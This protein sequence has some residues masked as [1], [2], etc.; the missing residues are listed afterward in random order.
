[1]VKATSTFI[2][3]LLSLVPTITANCEAPV[4]CQDESLNR[5]NTTECQT[6]HAFLARGSNSGFPGHLGPL[7]R[8]VCTNLTSGS[9]DVT[10]GYENIDYPANSS[11]DGEG[12]WCKS[13]HI[14]ATQGQ[15]Q[16]K[17]Y[18][19]RCPDAKLVLLGFSQGGSVALDVL[20]G[21]GGEEDGTV[22][23]CIQE[24]SP[25]LNPKE[26]PGS[27]IVAAVVFGAVRRS[28]DQPFTVKNGGQNYNGTTPRTG[29]LAE[30]LAQFTPVLREYCNE[31]DPIC[32]P[33]SLPQNV[34]NHLDYF[35]KFD[36]EASEWIVQ[37]AGFTSAKATNGNTDSGE[38]QGVQGG[39]NTSAAV[40]LMGARW[41]VAMSAFGVVV[42][43]VM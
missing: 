33:E 3:S 13:A 7:I 39:N 24:S 43:G 40:G 5:L 25:A 31:H 21:G 8:S 38:R 29:S 17:E 35:S 23:G 34:E 36:D 4:P 16:M 30:G 26:V 37:K 14:G 20:G 12:M 1:M 10:C 9:S 6:V 11:R 19:E 27:K 41:G 18:S 2:L 28:A 42:A 32:A 22:F 15:K